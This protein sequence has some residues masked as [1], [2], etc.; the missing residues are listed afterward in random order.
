MYNTVRHFCVWRIE[1]MARYIIKRLLLMIPVVFAITIMIFSVMEL[2]PGDPAQ[3]ILGSTATQ[4][5]IETL[6]EEIGLNRSYF[7]RIGEYLYNV[8]FKLDFG[9]SY[10]TGMPVTGA[11]LLRLPRTLTLGILAITMALCIGIP[12]GVT[13]AVHQNG[14][15]DQISM[16]IALL[17]VSIPTF[18]LALLLVMLF[19]LNL[20]WLPP[21]GIGSWQNY[22]LP[23]M[24]MSVGG[25]AMQARQSRSSMLEVIRADYVVTARAKGLTHREV[26]LKHALPNALNPIITLAGQNLAI[27]FGGSVVI[28]NVF[29]FPGIGQYLITAINQRDYPIV[30]GCVILLA[31]VFS[32]VM[33]LMDLA[34][35]FVDP[36]IRARY[37]TSK[38]KRGT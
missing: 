6:R 32:V 27:I 21:S 14:F 7:V 23:C 26:I 8:Y 37:S 3:I 22:V 19:S 20:G 12:L 18:W 13:A 33:L 30:N 28:E 25:I 15:G 24:A 9:N 11:I 5:D 34:Y 35:G 17:G 29:S 36:R 4:R 10:L 1:V 38:K 31:V 16:V 2:V